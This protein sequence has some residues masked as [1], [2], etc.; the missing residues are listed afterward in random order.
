MMNTLHSEYLF[1]DFLEDYKFDK[2][3]KFLQSHCQKNATNNMDKSK[4]PTHAL[5]SH[6]GGR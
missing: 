5:I 4:I 6:C 3:S 2:L 1:G